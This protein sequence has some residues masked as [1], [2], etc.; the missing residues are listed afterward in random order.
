VPGGTP[1]SVN[2]LVEGIHARH[3]RRALEQHA[4]GRV[5][6]VGCGRRPFDEVLRARGGRVVGL[7]VDAQ[8]YAR[9]AASAEGFIASEDGETTVAQPDVW[10]SGLQLPFGDATFD[11]A[12]SFQV[13]EHVQQ[14]ARLLAEIC[15]VLKP[16]GRLVL[17]APHIWGIH[18]EPHDYYRFTP[19]GLR[20]LAQTVG[21]RVEQV[22]PLAGYWVTAGARFSHYLTQF[23]KLYLH[24]LTRPLMALVQL[25]CLGLDRL[26]PVH[27]D[28]WNHLMIARKPEVPA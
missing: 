20:Y 9:P 13:L 17:T 11:T 19:Y 27:G 12:V 23:E 28:A 26:H 24:A 2:W 14:P 1:F 10:G 8:R 7:E 16:G 18:E 15:R 25:L 22:V 21:L 6:D 3:V 5:L 4:H